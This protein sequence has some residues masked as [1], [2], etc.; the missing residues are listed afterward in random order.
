MPAGSVPQ[1]RAQPTRRTAAGSAGGPSSTSASASPGCRP[2]APL[3]DQLSKG[4]GRNA[5]GPVAGGLDV[6]AAVAGYFDRRRAAHRAGPDRRGAGQQADADGAQPGRSRRRADPAPGLEHLRAAGPAG[7]QTGVS[8]CTSRPSAVAYPIR[9]RCARPSR[10]PRAAGADPRI[11]VLT[12]P[13]NPTGT[14]APPALVRE[15]CAIAEGRTCSSSPTRSTA[16][17]LHDPATPCSAPPRSPPTDRGH[18]RAEQ[19]PGAGRLAH[20]RGRFPAGHGASTSGTACIS[21]ASEVWSTLAGPMQQVAA[22]AFAEPPEIRERLASSARLHGAVARA[23]TASWWP[24]APLPAADRRF[25][26]YPDFE[27]LRRAAGRARRHRSDGLQR[28]LLEAYGVLVLAG[29]H[30]GDDGAPCASRP[31]PA[32]STAS[33]PSSSSPLQPRPTR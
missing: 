30:L 3:R 11:L 33:T 14:L 31:P 2:F 1:S 23:V 17:S 12:L 18:H 6:R 19:E 29:H 22:Y 8:A 27:P 28:H 15:I 4:A 13:D 25:Y 16:T 20:R 26:I 32:C 9:R 5:Y 10:P 21:V 7:R 24:S